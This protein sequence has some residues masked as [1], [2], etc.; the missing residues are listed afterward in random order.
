MPLTDSQIRNT[1]TP[2]SGRTVLTDGRGL[3]LR[4]TQS[5]VRSWSLQYR[6]KGR[7]KKVT[8]GKWPAVN[9]RQ[10]RILADKQ[11]GLIAHGID[12]LAEKRAERRVN[13]RVAKIWA[14]FD[15]LYISENVRPSTAKEYRRVAMKEILPSIGKLELKEVQRSDVIRLVDRVAKRAKIMANRLLAI[16]CKFLN[17]CVAR[18][19]IT[20]NPAKGIEKPKKERSRERVLTLAEMRAIY[21]ATE[22]LSEGN[23]LLVRLLLLTGQRQGVIARLTPHEF[24]EDHLLIA[25]D[26]NKS[27]HQIKVQLT[28]VAIDL[29]NRFG[30]LD[31]PFIVSTTG[32]KR[33]VSG[34]SKLKAKLNKLTGIEEHWRF[35]DFRRGITTHME[36]CGLDRI[37][38]KRVLNHKDQSVTGIYARAE[39]T[40]FLARVFDIWAKQLTAPD[41]QEATNVVLFAR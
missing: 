39:H 36:E 41:G 27:D 28:D 24:R 11:R 22:Q 23:A 3:Q 26:R 15:E 35:H 18:G 29:I 19:Y 6:H 31:G 2:S 16:I 8:I 4:I 40:E 5:N 9:C 37:Y 10:A 17:W 32:G 25:G 20:A 21:Q 38:T 1:E 14:E 12:P 34:F 33:P 30:C 7:M 13:P